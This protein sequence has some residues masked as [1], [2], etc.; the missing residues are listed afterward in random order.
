MNSLSLSATLILISNRCRHG[1]VALLQTAIE[2]FL[3]L[4][5]KVT[6]VIGSD[7]GLDVRRESTSPRVEIQRFISEMHF[8]SLIDELAEFGPVLE[9]PGASV[10]FVHDHAGSQTLTK[11]L[12]HAI[13][14]WTACFSS[15]LLLFQ[16][17]NNLEVG[18]RSKL[19][20]GICL[21]LQGDA[22]SLSCRRDTDVGK[23][24]FQGWFCW[25][26]SGCRPFAG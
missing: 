5:T 23:V 16:P 14:D 7:H 3:G 4:F 6:Y 10:D 11:S 17:L 22:F 26:V 15:R 9:V 18:S 12:D 25:E 19:L 1:E 24:S 20:D 13:E 2:A 21:L 8:D